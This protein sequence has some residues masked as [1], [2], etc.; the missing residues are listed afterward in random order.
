MTQESAKISRMSGCLVT[1]LAATIA[2]CGGG[3]SGDVQGQATAADPA[4][5]L[6]KK[7]RVPI[8]FAG[9]ASP[10]PAA[11][12]PVPAP[13]P[14]PAPVVPAPIVPAPAP[15]PAPTP[16]PVTPIAIPGTLYIDVAKIPTGSS[17]VSIDMLGPTTDLGSPTTEG[18]FRT[19]CD[20]SHMAFDDPIVYPGQPGRSH[21]H[22]FFGNTGTTASSTADSIANAGN[23]TCRGGT[24]NRTAYWAP[25]MIDTKDGTPIKP[26]GLIVYYKVSAWVLPGDLTSL[27]LGLRMVA[28]DPSASAPVQ[29]GPASF[30]CSGYAQGS[31]A[32]FPDGQT[33]HS[34]PNC[35]VGTEV[36]A[37]IG[38]PNCW[39]G[40][41]LDSP[42][43]R[44]HMS[45]R[46]SPNPGLKC[47]ASHPVAVPQ[48]T[49]QVM[50]YVTE[51]NAPLR[52]RLASDT[53]D[54]KIP[55]GYS[56]HGDWF[57]GW[58]PEIMNAWVTNCDRASKDCAAHL[59]GDGRMMLFGAG[60]GG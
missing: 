4:Q 14:A 49:F 51:A 32:N 2:A 30:S 19:V 20:F 39:D 29:F 47:P 28:G 25:A 33:P 17:G 42:D 10:S 45:Y 13:S 27:P 12:A 37:T 18:A 53:Y 41:H 43:H 44:S 21:L 50:Y 34:L 16:A 8:A 31:D 35:P 48:V 52:W 3:Q 38:F 7:I 58:K 24:I 15:A 60:N 40:V 57:N 6:H 46:P 22:A 54:P 11:P 5:G 26:K 9:G 56:M 1:V 36:W 55:A 59:L 23:S